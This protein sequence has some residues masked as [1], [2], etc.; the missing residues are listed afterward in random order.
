MPVIFSWTYLVLQ[1]PHRLSRILSRPA[2]RRSFLELL[3][4]TTDARESFNELL[5]ES[6]P[7]RRGCAPFLPLLGHARVILGPH[8]SLWEVLESTLR[9]LALI[10]SMG[11]FQTRIRGTGDDGWVWE[12]AMKSTDGLKIH[13]ME[14]SKDHLTVQKISVGIIFIIISKKF[15]LNLK[16]YIQ[17]IISDYMAPT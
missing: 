12:P 3:T 16:Q 17:Y 15:S 1:A 9:G 10:S 14:K 7:A 8:A 13:L 4:C 6:Y 11:K 2:R 5:G